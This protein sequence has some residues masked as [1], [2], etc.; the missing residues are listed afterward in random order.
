[1]TGDGTVTGLDVAT[2]A[3]QMGG[4]YHY[5]YDRDVDGDIDAKDVRQTAAD[6]GV[7]VPTIDTEVAQL[8]LAT[9]RYMDVNNA[10][11]DG[12]LPATQYFEGHGYHFLNEA[13]LGQPFNHYLPT[14][15]N[16][17]PQGELLAAFHLIDASQYGMIPP[18]GYTGPE[19]LWHHHSEVCIYNVGA[20]TASGAIDWSKPYFA[21]DVS[22]AVGL[23]WLPGLCRE[24]KPLAQALG[25]VPIT[26]NLTEIRDYQFDMFH[27]VHIWVARPNA[28]GRF[29]GEHPDA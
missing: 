14:G 13:L 18:E 20:E 26:E 9:M 8:A 1:V 25:I 6:I 21:D 17:T 24:L 12:Y 29:V 11:A 15:L 3:Q 19:D 27:M 10:I 23:P 2:V 22:D 7:A 16:Y 28:C 5:L 4:D